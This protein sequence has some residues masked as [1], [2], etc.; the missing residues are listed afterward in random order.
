[1]DVAGGLDLPSTLMVEFL[2][3]NGQALLAQTTVD[4]WHDAQHGA[5]EAPEEE[6]IEEDW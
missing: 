3:S 1:M 6:E 2:K 5:Q 4:A